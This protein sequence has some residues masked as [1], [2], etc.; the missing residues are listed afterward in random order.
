MQCHLHG[1][2]ECKCKCD[3]WV[4]F[5][6]LC[7]TVS[8]FS[9]LN[10]LTEEARCSSWTVMHWYILQ[11]LSMGQWWSDSH[12]LAHIRYGTI[13]Q[14]QHYRLARW[15]PC[16]G[17]YSKTLVTLVWYPLWTQRWQKRNHSMFPYCLHICSV[18]NEIPHTSCT[19][20]HIHTSIFLNS[21]NSLW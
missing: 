14:K 16:K 19:Q 10:K 13:S 20:A 12:L 5:K 3:L 7:L 9:F 21:L 15:L 17:S 4:D 1:T 8:I 18:A 11:G 2:I 6:S